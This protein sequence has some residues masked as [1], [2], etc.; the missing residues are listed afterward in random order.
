MVGIAVA[1]MLAPAVLVAPLVGVY[2]DR[3]N[4]RDAMIMADIFQG[5]VVM[6][7]SFLFFVNS[8]TFPVLL[9][10][11]FMLSAGS[12]VTSAATRAII[13]SLASPDDLGAANGLFSL[14]SSFNQLA[15]MGLGGIVVAI[16]GVA[17]PILYDGFT[18]FAAAALLVVIPR[19][20]VAL[21]QPDKTVKDTPKGFFFEL[22]E[23]FR[24]IRQTRIL[25]E[26]IA[27]AVLVNFFGAMVSALV[28]PYIKFVLSGNAA[29]F[30]FLG[31][32]SAFGGIVGAFA[33]GKMNMRKHVGLLLFAGILAIGASMLIWGLTANLYL[34]L[35]MGF[36]TGV[37]SAL[38]NVP[39]SVLIQAKVPGRL[40]GRVG[41]A[42]S[43]SNQSAQ[44]LAALIAGIVVLSLTVGQIFVLSG[45]AM[46]VAAVCGLIFFKG[47]RNAQF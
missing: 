18:F 37:G 12:Q 7:L 2:V 41:S 25:L 21:K 14:T 34:A 30:G 27:L 19:L 8:L 45:I 4:R 26:V 23:G 31:A 11:L 5:G 47:L 9:V 6:A 43:A 42:L 46:L 16:F 20:V 39:F 15:S 24:F 10:L 3:I 29:A 35:A 32:A 40:I 44:P 13:P 36:V 17:A 22:A 28:A 33:A 38:A 1:V